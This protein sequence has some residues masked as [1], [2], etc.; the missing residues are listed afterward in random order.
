MSS[1][2]SFMV[3]PRGMRCTAL[4]LALAKANAGEGSKRAHSLGL[5]GNLLMSLEHRLMKWGTEPTNSEKKAS[6][7]TLRASSTCLRDIPESNRASHVNPSVLR[8][9]GEYRVFRSRS[10]RRVPNSFRRA[11]AVQPW[12]WSVATG[13][14]WR[15][16]AFLLVSIAE[17]SLWLTKE[18]MARSGDM[19]DRPSA[20]L[21][22]A[23]LPSFTS[24]GLSHNLT[25]FTLS[26]SQAR[27][28][29]L[30]SA[31]KHST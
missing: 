18:A 27:H 16:R 30:G 12:A 29:V 7:N 2:H 6:P 11:S 14:S 28:A 19:S 1:L 24:R 31:K 13:K 8:F 5:S 22:T 20:S 3:K 9:A 23:R 15:R 17:S 25:F 4:K 10:K 26:E 21:P